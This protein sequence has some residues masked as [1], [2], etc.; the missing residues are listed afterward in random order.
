[1]IREIMPHVLHYSGMLMG[2]FL[3]LWLIGMLAN[4]IIG[5]KPEKIVPVKSEESFQQTSHV[6]LIRRQ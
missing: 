6:K 4:W 1:M 2:I 5:P 3:G